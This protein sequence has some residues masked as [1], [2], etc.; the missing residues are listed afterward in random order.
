MAG[1]EKEIRIIVAPLRNGRVLLPGSVVAEVISYKMPEPLKNTPGWML[2]ELEWNSWQVPVISFTSLM[3]EDID[4]PVSDQTRILIFKT[5]SEQAPVP[6]VGILIQGLPTLASVREDSLD[7]SIQQDCP[8][9]VFRRVLLEN[10]EA[11]VPDLDSI[12][13][14]IEATAYAA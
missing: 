3:D 2:G 14:M 6:F 7:E 9:G 13:L 5:L 8:N 12:A 1:Q 10:G 4:D 11:L